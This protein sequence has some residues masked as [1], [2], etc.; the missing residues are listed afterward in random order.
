MAPHTKGGAVK[1][2]GSA[3][4]YPSEGQTAKQ[5]GATGGNRCYLDG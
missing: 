3:F 4:I 1:R 5:M 2:N